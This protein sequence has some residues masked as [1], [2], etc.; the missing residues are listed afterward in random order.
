MFKRI[1]TTLTIGIGLMLSAI[2]VVSAGVTT[3]TNILAGQPVIEKSEVVAIPYKDNSI[4]VSNLL[5]ITTDPIPIRIRNKLLH[6]VDL[7]ESATTEN[8]AVMQNANFE[9][10]V[11]F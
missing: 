8:T 7:A 9:R 2:S 3:T 5:F 6:T 4:L 11:S 10:M 1:L